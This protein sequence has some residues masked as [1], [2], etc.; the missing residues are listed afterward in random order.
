[1]ACRKSGFT[2]I[3]LMASIVV[4]AAIA[5]LAVVGYNRVVEKARHDNA[6]MNLIAIYTAAQMRVAKEGALTFGSG[7]LSLIND[8]FQLNIVDPDFNYS[9][10]YN[11]PT[12]FAAAFRTNNK[13]FIRFSS[14]NPVNDTN[15]S[16]IPL[17]GTCP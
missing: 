9:F 17:S 14:D 8:F 2:L 13:Y 5:A 16:C 6:R 15:P 4:M 10:D 3:E 1:M 7:Q 11:H 12:I